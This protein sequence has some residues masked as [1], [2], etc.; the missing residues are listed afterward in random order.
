VQKRLDLGGRRKISSFEPKIDV[1][2]K[3][4]LCKHGLAKAFE[5][6]GEKLEPSG[7]DAGEDNDC[8]RRK[9]AKHPALPKLKH[10]E[11]PSITLLQNQAGDE[12]ARDDEEDIHANISSRAPN[13]GVKEQD[14]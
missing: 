11:L 4:G 12:I 1:G 5:V 8:E 13:T 10:S 9:Y 2:N 14:R 6:M 7:N 3:H